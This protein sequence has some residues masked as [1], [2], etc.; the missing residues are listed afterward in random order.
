MWM[1]CLLEPLQMILFFH[2]E[3]C[4]CQYMCIYYWTS[5][6][7]QMCV[8]LKY[9]TWDNFNSSPWIHTILSSKTVITLGWVENFIIRIFCRL[10]LFSWLSSK[11][12]Q[13]WL[14]VK[15]Q[16]TASQC[17]SGILVFFVWCQLSFKVGGSQE[18]K[19][20]GVAPLKQIDWQSDTV[21]LLVF[22]VLSS[23]FLQ[24]W[25][26]VKCC[27]KTKSSTTF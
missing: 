9:C 25:L 18:F 10:H 17:Q 7:F 14:E 19:D 20:F 13:F 27:P 2:I 6:L 8:S 16:I 23:N 11:L 21:E 22:L 1:F 12:V 24:F 4:V 3:N 26:Q 5:I 15:H